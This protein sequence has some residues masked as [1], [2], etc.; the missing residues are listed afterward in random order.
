MCFAAIAEA[1]N[2]LIENKLKF[3]PTKAN[4]KLQESLRQ[5]VGEK[6]RTPATA[7]RVSRRQEHV[8]ALERD[9]ML[10]FPSFTGLDEKEFQVQPEIQAAQVEAKEGI[11]LANQPV[12][13]AV[14]ENPLL[15]DTGD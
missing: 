13:I 2:C 4:P 10:A 11:P 15:K 1:P 3:D 6:K 14:P 5:R 7:R 8:D 12:A 9:L